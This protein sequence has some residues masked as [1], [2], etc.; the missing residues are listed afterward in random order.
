V[1]FVAAIGAKQE[2]SAV[3]QPGGGT[4]DDPALTPEARAVCSLASRD[5]RL[6][7]ALPDQ[8]AVLIVV[9]APIGDDKE[10]SA[11]RRGSSTVAAKSLTQSIRRFGARG[12][13]STSIRAGGLVVSARR[14]CAG[15][16]RCLTKKQEALSGFSPRPISLRKQPFR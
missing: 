9:V 6:H 4:F 14:G 3:V 16:A 2:P 10:P 15:A 7:A 13:K 5:H 8:P 12:S 11:K 1:C